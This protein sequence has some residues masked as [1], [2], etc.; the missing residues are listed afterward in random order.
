M[1]SLSTRLNTA[2]RLLIAGQE[3]SEIPDVAFYSDIEDQWKNGYRDTLRSSI[4]D[5]EYGPRHTEIVDYPKNSISVRP[6]ARFSAR[7]RLIYDALVFDIA[8]EVDEHRHSS[9]YSYR[10]NHR[11]SE[12]IFWSY[13]WKLMRRNSLRVLSR[14]RRLHMASLDV[15]SFYEHID[16]DYLSEDLNL[17]VPNELAVRRV[18]TFLDKFQNVNHAW[19]LPQGS[20]ASGIL[21]NVYLASTDQYLARN[22]VPFFRYSDD[23][24]VFDDD[25]NSLRDILIGVNKIF[26]ARKLSMAAHKTTIVDH[27][28]ACNRLK[29]AREASIDHGVF[30]GD[31]EVD[32]DI[33]SYFDEVSKWGDVDTRR[34]R[35][36]LNK[37][38]RRH[39]DYAVSW[40]LNNL[41]YIAHVGKEVFAYLAVCEH[42]LPEIQ[43]K[44]TSFMNSQG[45]NSYPYIEQRVLRYVI[46]MNV[47]SEQMKEAAWGILH[48]RNREEFP[49][50]FAARYLG[51]CASVAESQ[52]LRHEF[53][54]EP[55]E[56]MRRAL[57]I[58]LYESSYLSVRYRRDVE[59]SFPY[60]RWLC[61]YLEKN[62]KIPTSRG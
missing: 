34:L 7:D 12:P 41:R 25:W 10:W 48:D 11:A 21:A 47:N 29:N 23:I 58:S 36:A 2:L 4:L 37:L 53:E 44:L 13:S 46:R 28:T 16:V 14:N 43:R 27:D 39:D 56:A 42:R 24:S 51:R 15:S 18:S 33:H 22:R 19:G 5:Q 62:P 20:D 57:L 54:R 3:F 59:N 35:F 17:M 49:R 40:C 61:A 30:V 50:E 38:R 60:L 9:V 31:P 32:A 8:A 45:S 1:D 52:L 55:S 26:R 6:L